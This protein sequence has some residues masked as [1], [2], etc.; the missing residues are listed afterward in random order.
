M[1]VIGIDPHKGSHTAA[2]LDGN[3]ELLGELRVDA[4]HGQH[5]ELLAFAQRFE[6]RTWAIESASG[7]GALVAQ[8]LVAAGEIVVDVPP[9]LSAR[10]RLL[11]GDH[12]TDRHDARSA[13]IVALRH[14]QLRPVTEVGYRAVLRLRADRHHDLVAARTRAVC[15][16]HALLCLLIPGGQPGR[17]DEK[18]ARATLAELRHL[19]LVD[20]ERKAAALD[21]VADIGRLDDQLAR[22]K[23]RVHLDVRADNR[24]DHKVAELE[25][26]GGEVLRRVTEQGRTFITMADPEGNELDVT[27][28]SPDD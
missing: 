21:L 4:G 14:R 19:G 20:I 28:T 1:Y 2:V 15:R 5:D 26:A 16:L 25:A 6:P 27:G 8:Q 18:S 11:D 10:A 12:K 3:E 17:L 9:A 22:V 7:W 24:R 23:N 13:A